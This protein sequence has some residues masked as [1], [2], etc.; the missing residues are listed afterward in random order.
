MRRS[1]RANGCFV[2]PAAQI[3]EGFSAIGS[4]MP[5]DAS[6]PQAQDFG[7]SRTNKIGDDDKAARETEIS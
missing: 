5:L 4:N 2:D 7:G 3:S 6:S 1:A